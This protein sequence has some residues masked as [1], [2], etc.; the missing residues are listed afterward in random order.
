MNSGCRGCSAGF[1]HTGGMGKISLQQC[2]EMELKIGK[3]SS[4]TIGRLLL[5]VDGDLNVTIIHLCGP[6]I[7]EFMMQSV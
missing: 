2:W 3:D 6:H 1:A 7:I 5:R 4:Q